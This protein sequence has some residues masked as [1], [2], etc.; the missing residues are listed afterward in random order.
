MYFFK[1]WTMPGTSWLVQHFPS[2][3]REPGT[4]WRVLMRPSL[5]STDNSKVLNGTREKSPPFPA[6]NSKSGNSEAVSL[7][8]IDI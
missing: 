1:S 6:R 8:E 3:K 2:L 4:S 7:I 5:L